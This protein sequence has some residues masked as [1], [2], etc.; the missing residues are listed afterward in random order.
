MTTL[1]GVHISGGDSQGISFHHLPRH[2]FPLLPVNW[3]KMTV[4]ISSDWRKYSLG[5][6]FNGRVQNVTVSMDGLGP[7]LQI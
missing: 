4:D 7:H 3:I 5:I 6:S 2:P 1:S